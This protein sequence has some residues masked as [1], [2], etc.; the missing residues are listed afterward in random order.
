VLS[1]LL[2]VVVNDVLTCTFHDQGTTLQLISPW[3]SSDATTLLSQAQ[4]A[5]LLRGTPTGK[6]K[7][8]IY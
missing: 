8:G 3:M 2:T 4:N 7:D 5:V 1:H 6:G